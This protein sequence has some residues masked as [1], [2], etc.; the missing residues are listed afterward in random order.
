[1]SDTTTPNYGFDLP[2]VG[3]SQ[4]TWGG[5]LNANWVAADSAIHGLASGYLPLAGGG[6][7]NGNL[8]ISGTTGTNGTT[9]FNY[10]TV[11]DFWITRSS[12]YRELQFSGGNSFG[13]QEAT[14]QFQWFVNGAQ[15]MT[16]SPP[17]SLAVSAGVSIA[18]AQVSD[19]DLYRT[20]PNR[21]L[22]WATGY[23]I[24]FSEADNG[25][26]WNG[27]SLQLMK[28]D[29]LGNL[30]VHGTVHGTNVLLAGGLDVGDVLRDLLARV[31][32]LE[33]LRLA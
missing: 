4:D 3:A 13:L 11:S 33:A 19:F 20:A 7:I 23:N 6:S 14:Q 22:Q 28:L 2:A 16:L 15:A 9:Y 29:Y 26:T 10:P 1:M 25:I 8:Y 12:P 5:K 30:S 32:D 27:P 31:A 21:V 18:T 17:G 24:A